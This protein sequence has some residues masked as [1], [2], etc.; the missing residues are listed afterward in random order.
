MLQTG[1]EAEDLSVA[2][3][4]SVKEMREYIVELRDVLMSVSQ[5]N[6][7][8]EVKAEFLG[9]FV[10]LKESTNHIID[11]LNE[12]IGQLK[13]AANMLSN[14]ALGVSNDA[15]A[16]ENASEQQSGSIEKLIQE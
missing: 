12:M 11:F 3:E 10:V 1:D 8:V 13:E 5:E 15:K 16:V 6:L 2:L 4:Y 7:N 9:D 14:A